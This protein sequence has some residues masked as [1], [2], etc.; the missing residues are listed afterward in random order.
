MSVLMT[1]MVL[2][3]TAFAQS[4]ESSAERD[5]RSRLSVSESSLNDSQSR[6]KDWNR[7]LTIK[8]NIAGLALLIGNAAVEVDLSRHL[9]FNLPVYYSALD[10]FKPTVKFR[11]LAV[12]PEL[13]WNFGRPDGLYI[14]SHFGLAYFNFA[15][16]GKYRIQPL[17][18]DEPLIGGGLSIGYS[19]PLSKNRKWRLEV[20]VGGGA[21]RFNRDKFFN[22]TNGAKAGSE[23]GTYIGVD[24]ASISLSYSFDL[25]RR[26]AE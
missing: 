23:R 4:Y 19:I 11:T 9:S 25:K 6:N 2:S 15:T 12:Q 13:R 17:D 1:A 5:F 18:G 22:E 24:N 14:G 16:G 10:Y 26:K 3:L 8:T 7:K 20:G 21:Y